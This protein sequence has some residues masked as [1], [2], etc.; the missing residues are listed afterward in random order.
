[1]AKSHRIQKSALV[2]YSAEQM[3]ALVDDI[4]HYPEF[5][6]DC[7]QAQELER[8]KGSVTASLTISHSGFTKA[9]TTRN[10]LQP[11]SRIIMKL[12]DG[13][14]KQLE[15]VWTFVEVGDGVTK[16]E[17][18]LQF[19]FANALVGLAFG[20]VFISIANKLVDAYKQRA[21][22]VYQ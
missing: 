19:E 5:L 6:P 2:P 14:F 18:D 12:V 8:T 3:Y 22:E 10:E 9:F 1:M 20:K 7:S 4:N 16:I 21:V 15:G 11:F 13:P 17:L